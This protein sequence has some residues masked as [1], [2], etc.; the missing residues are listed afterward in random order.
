MVHITK[1]L[2]AISKKLLICM[3]IFIFTVLLILNLSIASYIAFFI[4]AIFFIMIREDFYNETIDL[5]WL[6]VLGTVFLIS[7]QSIGLF[8]IRF[9]SGYL[10]FELLRLLTTKVRRKTIVEDKDMEISLMPDRLEH[11]YLYIFAASIFIYLLAISYFDVGIPSVL[12]PAYE[13]FLICKEMVT[14]SYYIL[15]S[16]WCSLAAIIFLLKRRLSNAIKNNKDVIYGYGDGDPYILAIFMGAFGVA[17]I[18]A[19]FAISL[20]IS[21]LVYLI[22]FLWGNIH[23]K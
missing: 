10:A 16:L 21:A 18:I 13:G 15:F 14:G 12:V 9:I 23:A 3:Y 7:S 2:E 8:C 5:R 22:Y 19:V 20:F 4:A 11:G 6:A 17:Q 1:V